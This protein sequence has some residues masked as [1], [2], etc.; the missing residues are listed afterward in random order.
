GAA[1]DMASAL[2]TDPTLADRI[3]VIAMAYYNWPDGGDEWN[4]KNDPKAW[5]VLLES[6]AP[7]AVGDQ[8]VCKRDL[9]MNSERART[10]FAERGPEGRY[11]A[12]IFTDWMT[13][14]PDLAKSDWPVWD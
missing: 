9:A 4:V 3:E 14:H 2:L 12:G 11:I 5:Q 6:R 7:L 10:L 1:T 8:A 13:K